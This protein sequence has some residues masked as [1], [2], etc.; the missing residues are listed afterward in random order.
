MDTNIVE[1]LK[2]HKIK[3]LCATRICKLQFAQVKSI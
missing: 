1:I 3:I 2:A